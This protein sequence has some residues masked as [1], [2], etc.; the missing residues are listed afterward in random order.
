MG[1]SSTATR[2]ASEGVPVD[3]KTLLQQRLAAP[4]LVAA[5]ASVPAV[6]LTL[7]DDPART[8][9]VVIN[10]LSGAVLIAET[11]VL[12][13]LADDKLGWLKRNRWLVGLSAIVIP[14]VLFAAGPLQLLRVVRAVGALRIVRVG[15]ILK[16]GRLMRERAGL[17]ST[18]QRIVGAAV[19]LLV[20]LFV[21]VVLS[22]PTSHT[23]QLLDGAVR[24][25]GMTGV[26]LAG[27]VLGLATYVVRS[28]R[29]GTR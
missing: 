15:R 27:V 5:L 9:G 26:L 28:A 19:G 1:P 22:D 8:A 14:A 12:F 23:R 7:L 10:T 24:H 21:A 3:R 18:W 29:S 25:V 4:V 6:F 17:N 16:A 11:V 13:A 20:A 2:S